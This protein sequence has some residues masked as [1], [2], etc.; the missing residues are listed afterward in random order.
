MRKVAKY[1]LAGLLTAGVAHAAS[2]GSDNAG[3]YTA[4]TN[5]SNQGTG[6]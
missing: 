3:N 6:F 4:W 5:G 2:L 1:V